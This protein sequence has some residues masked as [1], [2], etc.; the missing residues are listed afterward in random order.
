MMAM[1]VLRTYTPQ[2]SSAANH[3]L[4]R[5]QTIF[6]TVA[7]PKYDIHTRGLF[8]SQTNPA[9]LVA[10]VQYNSSKPYGSLNGFVGSREFKKAFEGFN[11]TRFEKVENGKLGDAK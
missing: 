7:H 10:L 6:T 3:L 1:Y 8:T 9:G 2:S 4:S 11:I 5:L